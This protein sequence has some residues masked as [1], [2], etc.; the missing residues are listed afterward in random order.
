MSIMQQKLETAWEYRIDRRL[1][2]CLA[3]CAELKQEMGLPTGNFQSAQLERCVG[4]KKTW[5]SVA[6]LALLSASLVR[7]LQGI[8]DGARLVGEVEKFV[9]ER[10]SIG[11]F[12][13]H[14][15]KGMIAFAQGDYSLALEHF[16]TANTK[17][18]AAWEKLS[19]QINLLLC[20]DTLGLPYE[21]TLQELTETLLL[22]TAS[23]AKTQ[24]EIQL[25]TFQ[26]RRSFREGKVKEA[27]SHSFEKINQAYYYLLWLRSLPYHQG[28][29]PL[30]TEDLARFHEERF[31]WQCGYRVRSLKGVLH[32][33]DLSPVRLTEF[34]DRLYLWV[35]KWLLSPE[36]FPID[37]VTSQLKSLSLLHDAHRMTVEDVYL[38]RNSLLWMGLFDPTHEKVLSQKVATLNTQISAHYP[39]FELESLFIHFCRALRDE[40][41]TLADD[42]ALEIEG[43]PLCQRKELYFCP[44]LQS[45][46]GKK[47]KIPEHLKGLSRHLHSSLVQ[48]TP[49][50]QAIT[51][52]LT[53][54]N[55]A[56][57]GMKKPL[58]SR[59]MVLA[60]DLLRAESSVS[61]EKFCDSCFGI[62]KFD[63]TIH[64]PRVYNLLARLKAM[65]HSKVSFRVRDGFV[66]SEGDWGSIVFARDGEF[67]KQLSHASEWM[68][69]MKV[70]PP[71]VDASPKRESSGGEKRTLSWNGCLKRK[72][73]ERILNRPRSTTNRILAEL[74]EKGTVVREGGARQ[75]R[76]RM[77]NISEINLESFT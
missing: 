64:M 63:S 45:L 50:K 34:S 68:H 76:Y 25:Q 55:V 69:F 65:K 33:E 1:E 30:S 36:S 37:K 46:R 32:P 48:K 17:A 14:F 77:K 54:F 71:V 60:L 39:L 16:L 49:R 19:N 59:P 23:P 27:F 22:A 5:E 35:W 15:E 7:A 18:E 42:L 12:P 72:D 56:I 20:L 31:F 24:V 13:L 11:T 58:H 57:P 52:D 74:I 73:I 75:A 62:S 43:H 4:G 29:E 41:N 47:V 6:S 26:M 44:L 3:L 51:V 2:E 70:S 21:K 40:K 9:R 28:Y 10:S 38:I 53:L 67:S 61:I 8:A 66:V